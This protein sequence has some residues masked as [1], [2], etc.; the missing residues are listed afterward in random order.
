MHHGG[1]SRAIGRQYLQ[2]LTCAHT[3]LCLGRKEKRRRAWV[4]H[5]NGDRQ[6]RVPLGCTYDQEVLIH[7][8]R[9]A[10]ALKGAG[11]AGVQLLR[12]YPALGDWISVEH[13]HSSLQKSVQTARQQFRCRVWFRVGGV[14]TADQKVQSRCGRHRKWCLSS[15][16]AAWQGTQ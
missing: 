14:D 15:C 13:V 8:H 11:V 16:R 6:A 1:D 3:P 10:K 9:G 12:L 2:A 7:G 5:R 4:T